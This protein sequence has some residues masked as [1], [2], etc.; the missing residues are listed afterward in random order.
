[1][2]ENNSDQLYEKYR[3]IASLWKVRIQMLI[4]ISIPVLLFARLALHFFPQPDQVLAIGFLS[5]EHPL[6]I[7]GFALAVSAGIEL[8]YML[9]TPGPDEAIE[10]L[11]LGLAAAVLMLASE[12]DIARFEVATSVLV[13]TA[14]IGFLFWVRKTYILQAE[15]K[16]IKSDGPAPGGPS[17]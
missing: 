9:F 15:T 10:P 7:V 12:K 5:S 3:P 16:D 11:I 13:F 8:A 4:G 17:A 14:C 2:S 1:M 6:H